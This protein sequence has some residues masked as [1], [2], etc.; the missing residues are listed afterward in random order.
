MV[1]VELDPLDYELI[2]K[3]YGMLFGEGKIKADGFDLMLYN[4]LSQMHIGLMRSE[5][6]DAKDK[7]DKKKGDP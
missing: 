2:E 3:W 6:N 1:D 5:I 7:L 4:K